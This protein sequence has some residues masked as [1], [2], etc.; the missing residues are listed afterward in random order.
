MTIEPAAESDGY[1]IAKAIYNAEVGKTG[2]TDAYE[3]LDRFKDDSRFGNA[4]VKLRNVLD[5]DETI[6][7]LAEYKGTDRAEIQKYLAEIGG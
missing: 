7:L 5:N 1:S 2:Y 3:V 4:V 6:R